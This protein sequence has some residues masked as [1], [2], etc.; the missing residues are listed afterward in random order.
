MKLMTEIVYLFLLPPTEKKDQILFFNRNYTH[1]LEVCSFFLN[2]MNIWQF[3]NP[4]N[5]CVRAFELINSDGICSQLLHMA[6]ALQK[7]FDLTLLPSMF[8][9]K[10]NSK[11]CPEDCDQLGVKFLE[12]L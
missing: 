2:L 11:F 5:S 3:L 6:H 4:F 7:H 12:R 1:A 10:C 8:G 9:G